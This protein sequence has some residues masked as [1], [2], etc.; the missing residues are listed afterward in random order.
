ME[1]IENL[2]TLDYQG[3]SGNQLKEDEKKPLALPFATLLPINFR[4][5]TYH[6]HHLQKLLLG[7]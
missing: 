5:L 7:E 1:W 2:P 6:P 3:L 4:L